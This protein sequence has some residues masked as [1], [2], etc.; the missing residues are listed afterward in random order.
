MDTSKGSDDH[1]VDSDFRLKPSLEHL[2]FD[3]ASGFNTDILAEHRAN[4]GDGSKFIQPTNFDPDY[5]F[6]DQRHPS[7]A[8]T[9][10][11]PIKFSPTAHFDDYVDRRPRFDLSQSPNGFTSDNQ[12]CGSLPRGDNKHGFSITQ[13]PSGKPEFSVQFDVKD[14][15]P[16]EISVSANNGKLV[17]A[18]EFSPYQNTS[19][20]YYYCYFYSYEQ[21]SAAMQRIKMALVYTLI[22]TNT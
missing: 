2:P 1:S 10:F 20:Y 16:E 7:L 15:K 19:Y 3:F 12:S 11:N 17:I 5:Y 14:F 22:N 18:G 6:S 4:F 8:E 21:P 9:H 13:S